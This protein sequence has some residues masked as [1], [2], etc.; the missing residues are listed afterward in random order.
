MCQC[1]TEVFCITWS[2]IVNQ[3]IYSLHSASTQTQLCYMVAPFKAGNWKNSYVDLKGFH[4]VKDCISCNC[5]LWKCDG[6]TMTYICVTILHLIV[7]MSVYQRGMTKYCKGPQRTA[8]GSGFN[9]YADARLC[10]LS[11]ILYL[12]IFQFLVNL[13]YFFVCLTVCFYMCVWVCN[14]IRASVSALLT[15]KIFIQGP[16]RTT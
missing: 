1:N 6:Y 8:K 5:A 10:E 3:S 7:W 2:C 15:I 14:S 12:V 16:Q 4:M 11:K 13:L 9:V